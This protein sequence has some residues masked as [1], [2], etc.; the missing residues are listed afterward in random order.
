M[1]PTGAVLL[2]IFAAIALCGFWLDVRYRLLPNWLALLAAA[3]GLA[4][5][6]WTG[7]AGAAGL[8]AGH[9]FGACS[10]RCLWSDCC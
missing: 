3:T 6:A 9:G 8:A 1:S 10:F 2:A 4:A 5:A 7:G